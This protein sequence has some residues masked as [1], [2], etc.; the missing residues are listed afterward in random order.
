MK[1]SLPDS[2]RRLLRAAL[3][4]S[5]ALAFAD[6]SR[7]APGD[8]NNLVRK[9]ED[10]GSGGLPEDF[11][12]NEDRFG[13]GATRI[14]DLNGDGIEELAVGVPNDTTGGPDVGA[15]FV[16]SLDGS[17]AVQ[18][19]TKI[20]NG[21][22]G[23]PGGTLAGFDQF[24]LSCATVGDLDGDGVPELAVGAP[25]DDTGGD[26]RGAVYILYL[27]PGGG[28]KALTKIAN[29]TGGFAV[30]ADDAAFGSSCAGL[31]DLD[32]D[33]IPDLV[34]GSS[35]DPQGGAGSGAVH[36]LRL[37]AGGA[38][39]TSVKI[40][41]G[42]SGLPVSTLEPGGGFGSSCASLGDIDKDGVPDIAVGASLTDGSGSERGAVYVILLDDT[43]A[44]SSHTQISDGSGGLAGMTLAD[45]DHFGASLCNAGDLDGNCINDLW[46]GA[47]GDDTGGAGRGAIHVLLLESEGDVR[48]HSKIADGVAGLSGGTL[49]NGGEF[50]SSCVRIGD[51]D[52]D[53][54]PEFGV[55]APGDAGG[56]VQ[57]GAF[58]LLEVGDAPITVTTLLDEFDTPSGVNVSLRE[59]IRDAAATGEFRTIAFDPLLDGGSIEL[60]SGS[61]VF[62]LQEVRVSGAG[63][64]DGITVSGEGAAPVFL[65]QGFS[66]VTI[67]CLTIANGRL[68]GAGSGGGISV[69]A[70]SALCLVDSTVRDCEA[71]ADVG[72]GVGNAGVLFATGCSFLGN[73][74]LG[75]GGGIANEGASAELTVVNS[76]FSGNTTPVVAPGGGGAI[77]NDSSGSARF[78][79]VTFAENEAPNGN[80]GA[81]LVADGIVSVDSSLFSGNNATADNDT[82]GTV[83]DSD[84]ST[85]ALADILPL[86]DYGGKTE[87][88]PLLPTSAAK[89]TGAFFPVPVTDQRGL[90]FARSRNGGIDPGAVEAVEASDFRPDN[91]VGKKATKF[92]GNDRYNTTG[93]K[94]T[95]AVKLKGK[96]KFKTFIAVQNDGTIPDSIVL[97]ATPPKSRRLLVNTFLNSGSRE[98]VTAQIY[99]DG[100]T[101][102][103]LD[104]GEFTVFRSDIRFKSK[105]GKVKQRL[106]YTSTSSLFDKADAVGA[107]VA[108]KKK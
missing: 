31:G 53:G 48:E 43:G 11:L 90:G 57:R 91:L 97:T 68:F 16:V 60:A 14:G 20:A 38:V 66:D 50:G 36:I 102:E 23:L 28:V 33:G 76:T 41:D 65:V 106:L 2:S 88:R 69:D 94:Q 56:G 75:G 70:N 40:A 19:L 55:G 80:G 95:L 78:R 79:H 51:I 103:G 64:P 32:G 4:C 84:N 104:P 24:G 18:A 61:L 74:A 67:E 86:G 93:K 3:A 77:L 47:P 63:L 5:L 22:A 89:N 9:I 34:V 45:G 72:G 21:S 15:V 85:V 96:K 12:L 100:Y 6:I 59:A 30:L 83:I 17:G 81:L 29:N 35:G 44:V 73:T 101:V 27:T 42:L 107:E 105:R 8:V 99:A 1:L 52:G 62:N 54:I 37:S 49:A 10:G 87:T 98:N 7:A 39:Q 82:S 58:Y 71:V 46:I 13:A 108:K 25:G 92:G 26:D